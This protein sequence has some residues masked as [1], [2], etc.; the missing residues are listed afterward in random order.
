MK[1]FQIL[2]YLFLV[3]FYRYIICEF[4]NPIK[5]MRKT[6]SRAW[7]IS[8]ICPRSL[9]SAA[10]AFGRGHTPLPLWKGSQWSQGRVV[11]ISQLRSASQPW[12][13][14]LPC[15]EW[16]VPVV[17]EAQGCTQ[18]GPHKSRL[19]EKQLSVHREQ[20]MR[21]IHLSPWRQQLFLFISFGGLPRVTNIL[22]EQ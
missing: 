19:I 20:S 21:T 6:G 10:L 14:P 1:F 16:S 2:T 17:M 15:A 5:Q 9:S 8:V 7:E 11:W 18:L 4:I 22:I 12:M 3:L 13:V